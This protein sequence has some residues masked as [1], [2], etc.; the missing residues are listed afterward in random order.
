MRTFDEL[1]TVDAVLV[2]GVY[3]AAHYRH[4]VRALIHQLQGISHFL[5]LRVD[6]AVQLRV[7]LG[8]WAWMG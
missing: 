2:D 7:D 1:L 5:N 8:L 6:C 4:G 3:L